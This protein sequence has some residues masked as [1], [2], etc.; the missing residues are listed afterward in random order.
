MYRNMYLLLYH[1]Y[2][3]VPKIQ[4]DFSIYSHRKLSIICVVWFV[5]LNENLYRMGQLDESVFDFK[6]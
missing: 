1:F 5:N 3:K 2:A 4:I 6:H